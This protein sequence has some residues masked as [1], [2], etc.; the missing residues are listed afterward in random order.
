MFKNLGSIFLPALMMTL[1]ATSTQAHADGSV[2]ISRFAFSPAVIEVP[3]G[4][5]VTWTNQ[6]KASHSIVGDTDSAGFS[7]DVLKQ[8]DHFSHTF[9]VAGTYK[10]RCGFHKYMTGTVVV[11]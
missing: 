2:S 7:S 1:S 8:G 9:S 11:K 6:D 3:A 4:S 10:Y 5:R